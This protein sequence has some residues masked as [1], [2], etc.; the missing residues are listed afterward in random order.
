MCGDSVLAQELT[1]SAKLSSAVSDVDTKI[2][3]M[4]DS[5]V[6]QSY[7]T[8]KKRIKLSVEFNHDYTILFEKKGCS[9]KSIH[10]STKEV[11]KHMQ[12]ELLDFG[13]EVQLEPNP[14]PAKIQTDSLVATWRYHSDFGEFV[15]DKLNDDKLLQQNE[16]S[17]EILDLLEIN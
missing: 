1:I 12:Y 14:E 6:V 8:S 2:I 10:V 5:I 4:K 9:E 7:N 17:V 3:L 15:F 11:P 13:F 16:V